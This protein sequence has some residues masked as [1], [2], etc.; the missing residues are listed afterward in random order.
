[1]L[2]VAIVGAGSM[3]FTRQ[4][5][6][7]LLQNVDTQDATFRLIDIDAERLTTSVQMVARMQTEV[8]SRGRVYPYQDRRE[9]LREVDYCINTIQV[10]G[11]S[12]TETDFKVPAA[13]GIRQTI[14]DT[15][16]IGGISRG[17]RTIPQ[18]LGIARDLAQ[19]S[20]E[21]ILLN[22]TNP[23][24]MIIL[25]IERVLPGLPVYGLCHSV[26]HTA[27]AL[28]RYLGVPFG[29]LE[30][31]SAGI[32]HMAWMLSLRHQGKDL[33]PQLAEAARNPEIWRQDA[34]RFELL[35]H[36]GY[37]VTESSEH[38][39]EY[40]AFFLSHNEEILRLE[41]PVGEYL[42]RSQENLDEY[43]EVRRLL[44]HPDAKFLLEASSEY[45]PNF[46][47]A[48]ESGTNWWFQGNVMNRHLIDNLPSDVAVEVPV[49]VNRH[50]VFPAPIG[51]LPLPLA[52]MN[53]PAISVQQL[54]VE[55]V[56]QNNRDL[57]YQAAMMD[58][59]LAAHLTL[60][61]ITQLVDD[62]LSAHGN[63]VPELPVSRYFRSS[64]LATNR[65]GIG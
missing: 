64:G 38:N 8:N 61:Q 60:D 17:L 55:A 22:Y 41:I 32:N 63:L 48:R 14:A 6:S 59:L 11:F 65:P 12:A 52:A 4:V 5:V 10:G 2:T 33:Y 56:I 25:A 34:V 7:D 36:L 29:E 16:G 19:L 20:P 13:Y 42:R 43:G 37:F 18:V 54:T 21:A 51:P 40:S 44:K 50:G 39:A 58:P 27:E 28:A 24:S 49:F 26:P 46:I 3:E 9:G 15:L 35:R 57:V 53:R 45:A 1:M 30:W 47:H 31:T 23:M 62:L